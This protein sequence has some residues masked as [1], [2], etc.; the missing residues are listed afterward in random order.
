LSS[1]AELLAAVYADP[2]DDEARRVYADVLIERGDPQ[3]E[4]IVL[5]LRRA[6]GQASQRE[7]ELERALLK[8]HAPTWLAPIAGVVEVAP[9]LSSAWA[10]S[11]TAF[12]R[13]F[14][15]TAYLKLVVNPAVVDDPIWNT[16]EELRGYV[17]H[18]VDMLAKLPLRALRRLRT[19][20]T[21]GAQDLGVLAR[22]TTPLAIDRVPIYFDRT[23]LPAIGHVFPD[24]EAHFTLGT[25]SP[26]VDL[27]AACGL[28]RARLT[29][30]ASAVPAIANLFYGRSARFERVVI[31]LYRGSQTVAEVE[32]TP[33]P[34][35]KYR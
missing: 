17:R 23:P 18:H 5:Q 15:T 6:A 22:R 1:E 27:L 31:D 30:H 12:E 9:G 25:R 13:G 33:G 19:S 20:Y 34:D 14:L 16:C 26:D 10:R 8:R 29:T 35:G 11:R 32:I 24:A 28:K 4:L 7:H 21:F 2:G 3:G